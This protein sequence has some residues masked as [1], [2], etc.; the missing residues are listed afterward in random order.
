MAGMFLRAKVPA[1]RTLLL[2]ASVIGGF[3]G[4]ILGPRV[5]NIVPIPDDYLKCWAA[6]PG[7]L[8][9][10]IFA[11]GPLGSGM[12]EAPKEKGAFKKN[13]PRVFASCGLFAGNGAL[14]QV[15]GMAIAIVFMKLMPSLNLYPVFGIELS[16]GY[17]GGHG[18]AG[19]YGGILQGYGF[20][21]WETAMG[22]A[23]TYATVGLVG[24]MILGIILI[25]RAARKGETQLLDKPSSL[26]A[27]TLYGFTKD[28]TKQPS[29]GRETT[30][31]SSV[32]T[33]TAH[34]AIILID[35]GLSYYLRGLAVAHKVFGLS[36]IPVWFYALILM[37][38]I[39]FILKKLGLS[40]MIDKKV[41]SRITGALSDIA[42]CGAV[43]SMNLSTIMAYGLPITITCIIGFVTTY[44]YC[45][46]LHKYCFGHKDYFFERSIINWGTNTGVTINGMMLLKICDPDYDTPALTDFSMGFALMSIIGIFTSPIFYG[47][48]AA[49][50]T[51]G[52]L[53]Y[54]LITFAGYTLMALIG[55]AMLKKE[56]PE[57]FASDD[58]AGY[59]VAGEPAVAF[60]EV[61]KE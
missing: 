17:C 12:N 26:P 8:I 54:G 61:G 2:P 33:I 59:G 19:G 4:L 31:S 38:V 15:V 14:Q 27:L 18:T 32:E 55:R 30:N 37:Y 60:A 24:G 6:L 49:E 43:A 46:P 35:C 29:M 50:N 21:Y 53:A 56:N 9:V 13:L 39:N 10:P 23:T 52:L 7:V 36:S 58:A 25:N 48:I 47:I 57:S 3:L 44:L 40:W 51:M 34:L 45:F 28:I 41:K 11:A 5:L 42:I 20:D 22:V 16:Q 1:F